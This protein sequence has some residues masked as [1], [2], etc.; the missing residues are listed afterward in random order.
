MVVVLIDGVVKLVPVPTEVPPDDTVYQLMVPPDAV[1]L[2]VT[3]PASQ[4]EAGV[5]DV[6]VGV[7]FTVATTGVLAKVQPEVATST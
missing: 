4:R 2:K 1:A 6:I 3:V 7:I 5:V